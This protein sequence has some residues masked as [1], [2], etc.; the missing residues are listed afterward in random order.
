MPQLADPTNAGN[1]PGDGP[2]RKGGESRST[3]SQEADLPSTRSKLSE[4]QQPAV[5]MMRDLCGG[6]QVVRAKTTTYLP[7]GPGEK[8]EA[9][10]ERLNRS[11]FFNAT[12]RTVEGLMGLVFRTDPVLGDD[13]PAQI[14]DHWEN[15]DMAGTHG[16]VFCRDLGE[17]AI[18]SGHA[19][20]FVDYPKT[21][22]EHG[23][24]QEIAQEVRPYWI[25]IK[26]EDIMSWRTAT[27]GGASYLTQIVLRETSMVPEGDYGEREQVRYRVLYREGGKVGFELIEITKERH[28]V[29]VDEGVYLNQ[30]EIPVAEI[31]TSGSESLFN[32]TP[33]LLDLGYLNVAHYQAWS[34]YVTSIHMTCV[35]IFVTIGMPKNAAGGSDPVVVGP[36]SGLNIPDVQ[37]NAFYVSHDGAALGSCKAALDDLKSDFGTLGLAMLAP[38]KRAAETADAK[39]LDKSTSDS[40]LAVSA[41]ALQDGI[42]NALKFHGKYLVGQPEGGSITIN[43]DFEGLLIDAPVMSAYAQLVNAGFPPGPVLQALQQGGRISEDVDLDE[44]EL[45][46]LMG[47]KLNEEIPPPEAVPEV[48]E[49]VE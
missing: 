44:L 31:G 48:V 18:T 15:I 38:Q 13:V 16:D 7:K 2:L 27:E 24:E 6:T 36:N 8:T 30:I 35:P 46:W 1:K 33:P 37:G 14:L 3:P 39:R 19:A 43:R 41:R 49:E 23:R 32:S 25:P 42:E 20:I 22:G 5:E 47:S 34:D 12:A 10:A 4:E 28:I 29:T 26:K 40:A 21:G 45:E 11:V 17:D 9:Y